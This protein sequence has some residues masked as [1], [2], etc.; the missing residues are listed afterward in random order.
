[1]GFVIQ[2]FLLGCFFLMTFLVVWWLR[3]RGFSELR[4][5]RPGTPTAGVGRSSLD[6]STDL[7]EDGRHRIQ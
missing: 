6:I 7:S 3:G 5:A 4:P 1:M 2:V